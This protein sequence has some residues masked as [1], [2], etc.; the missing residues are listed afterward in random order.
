MSIVQH[1]DVT[2]EQE[3]RQGPLHGVHA[4][5]AFETPNSDWVARRSGLCVNLFLHSVEEEV[6]QR[7]TGDSTVVDET[8]VVIG[9][10]RPTRYFRLGYA[11]TVWAQNPRDEHSLLGT[12]LEWCVATEKLAPYRDPAAGPLV[13]K[14]RDTPEGSEPL[15]VK[16]WSSLGTPPRPVL[17]LLVTV[18][19]VRPPTT[20]ESEP[21]KGVT[22]RAQRLDPPVVP[23][24]PP[25]R[26]PRP[27]GA[28]RP[29]RNVEEIV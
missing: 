29:R 5:V 27:A 9:Y 14:L 22:L 8:G 11:L 1:I 3:L 16:L 10:R 12:L 21:V 28:R 24:E 13:L 19:V 23:E 7:Q 6:T 17:D 25:A 20:V 4:E 15:S 18:P 2:L 26:A